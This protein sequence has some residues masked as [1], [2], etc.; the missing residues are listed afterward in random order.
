MA[1]EAVA[2]GKKRSLESELFAQMRASTTVDAINDDTT[3]QTPTA[4]ASIVMEE[5]IREARE[6]AAKMPSPIT[7]VMTKKIE[8]AR[9]RASAAYK[10]W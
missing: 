8:E 10:K 9:Q 5:K 4:A 7:L 6:R 1:A 2:F 3:R